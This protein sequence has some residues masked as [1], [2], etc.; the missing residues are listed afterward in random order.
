MD[1]DPDAGDNTRP[2]GLFHRSWETMTQ[3]ADLAREND[4]AVKIRPLAGA[5]RFKSDALAALEREMFRYRP[6][7]FDGL[8]GVT[9]AEAAN[10]RLETETVAADILRLCREEG[11]RYREIGVLIR[12]EDYVGLTA[13]TF[14]AYGIPFFVAGKRGGCHHP[15]AELLRSTWELLSAWRYEP[16]FRALR[17]GFF[18]LPEDEIDRL[19]NYVLEFGIR[20]KK[21]WLSRKDWTWERRAVTEDDASVKDQDALDRINSAR[22]QIMAPLK[23]LAEKITGK[24]TVKET[25]AALYEFLRE[26][27]VPETLEAWVRRDRA[28]G[29]LAEA[30]EHRQIWQDVLD[31]FDQLVETAGSEIFTRGEYEDVLSEGLEALEIGLVPPGLDYVSVSAFDQN[32]LDNS[33]AIYIMG[34]NEGIMPRRSREKGLFTDAER[35]R[36]KTE[37]RLDISSG[38]LEGILAE[39]YLIYRSFTA[40]REYL[41]VSY[42]LAGAEGVGLSPSALIDTVKKILPDAEFLSVPLETADTSPELDRLGKLNLAAGT[43]AVSKM[44]AAFRAGG[45]GKKIPAWWQ[46]VYNWSL[47]REDLRG[48]LR[49]ALGGLMSE[50]RSTKLEKELAASLFA[51]KKRLRGSVTQFEQFRKCPFW[52]FAQYGLKLRER[53]TYGFRALDLGNLLHGL[54]KNFGEE[55]KGQNR[56]WGELKPDEAAELC[57]TII[58]SLAPR[59]QN[60]IFLSNAGYTHQLERIKLLAERSVER[61]IAWDRVSKFHPKVYECSFGK[62]MQSMPPLTYDLG[63]DAILEIVGQIDRIDCDEGQKYFLIV[64]YKTG[65]ASI[66]LLEVYYGLKL[67]LLTYLLVARNFLTENSED[68]LPAGMLYFFLRY[69]S[70]RPKHRLEP[71]EARAMIMK[72]LK[73]PGWVLLDSEI[74]KSID[75]LGMFLKLRLKNDGSPYSDSRASVKTAEEFDFLLDYVGI[76]LTATGKMIMDGEIAPLPIKQGNSLS[77]AY[78]PYDAICGFDLKIPGYAYR[79]HEKID[80]EEIMNKIKRICA[81]NARK[82]GESS[83]GMDRR[84]A[85]RD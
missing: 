63:R 9:V 67:Q 81:A 48:K 72:K 83:D 4:V 55:L 44:V 64:D 78:C 29:R 42:S 68:R 43:V 18:P 50:P 60:E 8:R 28:A 47:K 32:S 70:I 1:S 73:M 82:K 14:A 76:L 30:A 3:L 84:A 38:G 10:R 65:N 6:R 37:A 69:P 34:A 2:M 5:E 85:S 19:E 24:M 41:F 51:P 21:N 77:C 57:Q 17:T 59:L 62:K 27:N 66:N 31:L 56:R 49:I 33:R 20:G 22:W 13:R 23:N 79:E 40:A 58:A 52:H 45:E 26:L 75:P 61:L 54:L 12:D 36:L 74:I 80:D 11:Y 16:I 71:S 15:L 25:T 53:L 35:L 39:K 46:D 7:S